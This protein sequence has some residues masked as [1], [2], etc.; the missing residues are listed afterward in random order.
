MAPGLRLRWG[1]VFVNT[2]RGCCGGGLA[3]SHTRDALASI[4]TSDRGDSPD[5]AEMKPPRS[6]SQVRLVLT[7]PGSG[8]RIGAENPLRDKH[9]NTPADHLWSFATL[10]RPSLRLTL[11]Q[12][13]PRIPPG[14]YRPSTYT[15]GGKP[16]PEPTSA[17]N[18]RRLRSQNDRITYYGRP[19]EPFYKAIH[20]AQAT[21]KWV[22]YV[23]LDH[24]G[25]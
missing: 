16:N 8:G 14:S 5:E 1:C 12:K 18:G 2:S 22:A 13:R 11:D 10:S 24:P 6:D 9:S 3:I 19:E 15:L 25:R 4:P 7:D 20:S 17:D 23:N 21:L